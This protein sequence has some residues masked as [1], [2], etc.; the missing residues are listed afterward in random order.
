[1][2][3]SAPTGA[4]RTGCSSCFL[5]NQNPSCRGGGWQREPL[6]GSLTVSLKP[7]LLAFPIGEGVP[8]SRD[9]GDRR[10]QCDGGVVHGKERPGA[11]DKLKLQET[12]GQDEQVAEG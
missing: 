9:E 8:R 7:H 2:G 5:G 4:Q 12:G 3:T 1:M 6:G 11:G 10:E